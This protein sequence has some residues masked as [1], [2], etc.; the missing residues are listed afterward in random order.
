MEVHWCVNAFTL[1][2]GLPCGTTMSGCRGI[3]EWLPQSQELPDC[4][5]TDAVP[6]RW[7]ILL[8]ICVGATPIWPPT[9]RVQ[10]RQHSTSSRRSTHVANSSPL[11]SPSVAT[12]PI[13]TKAAHWQQSPAACLEA[14]SNVILRSIR[15]YAL[16]SRSISPFFFSFL[17][18]PNKYKD[19]F[20]GC[21]S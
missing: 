6:W 2:K 5:T 16:P 10:R 11:R 21:H 12:S 4:P 19:C 14:A 8:L 13:T 3:G 20:K 1:C 17:I 18:I 7:E 9:T 15:E